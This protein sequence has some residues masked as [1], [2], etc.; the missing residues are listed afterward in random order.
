MLNR[1]RFMPTEVQQS[2]SIKS[3]RFA[4]PVNLWRVGEEPERWDISFTGQVIEQLRH[5]IG[6]LVR[7]PVALNPI[8]QLSPVRRQAA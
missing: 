2:L 1:S 3:V 8:M 6:R 4:A 5:R 7:K